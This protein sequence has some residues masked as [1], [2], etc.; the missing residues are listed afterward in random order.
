M[1]GLFSEVAAVELAFW[2]TI[3]VGLL[4]VP[5][6]IWLGKPM[7]KIETHHADHRHEPHIHDVLAEVDKEKE[8]DFDERTWLAK[9]RYP[10]EE[11]VKAVAGDQNPVSMMTVWIYV[12]T[13]KQVGDADHLKVF[14]NA[15]AANTWFKEHEPAG[16]AFEYPVIGDLFDRM[17]R[18]PTP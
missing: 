17:I 10:R 18:R 11:P 15:D 7:P 9:N 3:G 4:L 5:V 16:V 8:Q 12:D 14:G 13:S 1:A 6:M 2:T